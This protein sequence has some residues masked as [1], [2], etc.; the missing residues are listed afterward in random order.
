MRT[1]AALV[2]VLYH[3]HHFEN[4]HLGSSSLDPTR[5]PLYDVLQPAYTNGRFA[6]TLF[7][8]LSGFIFFH[9]FADKV[10]SG[11][12]T[13]REFAWRRFTRLYPLYIITLMVVVVLRPWF[14]NMWGFYF[15]PDAA[16][17][18]PMFIATLFGVQSW[19]LEQTFAYNRPAWSISIEFFLYLAFFLFAKRFKTRPVPLVLVAGAG[20][21]ATLLWHI[22]VARG[23]T[24]FFIGGVVV[25]VYRA[26]VGS[27][28]VRLAAS[29]SAALVVAGW[30]ISFAVG[31]FGPNNP[32]GALDGA[33][34]L[35]ALFPL[36]ILALA[37]IDTLWE[38]RTKA[39]ERFGSISYSMYLWHY[40]LQVLV[41]AAVLKV[42]PSGA[43]YYE[44]WVLAVF[45]AALAGVSLA[46]YHLIEV[47][48]QRWLRRL[49]FGAL[50]A[51]SAQSAPELPG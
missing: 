35:F 16:N 41:A 37:C 19:G 50:K 46:S 30:G 14:F 40:P 4:A 17:S 13:W 51:Q 7:F 18:L 47:P 42:E 31:L 11:E 20:L 10:N 5:Y 36:T 34:L 24:S 29:V 6:V 22:P 43:L 15:Q 44:P 3:W 48:A 33:A 32:Y 1:V 39:L 26:I 38:P 8:M 12:L 9:L 45:G 27:N 23:V 21:A 25:W 28:K 49:D 2:V